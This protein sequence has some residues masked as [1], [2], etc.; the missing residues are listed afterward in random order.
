MFNLA[1][2]LLI[3]IALFY[4][5]FIGN[6][7][8]I[9]APSV[10]VML[11]FIFSTAMALLNVKNWNINYSI[12]T[13]AILTLGLILFGFTDIFV[14]GLTK[15]RRFIKQI[16]CNNE[17]IKIASW[18]TLLIVFVD[19]LIV[20]LVFK[21]VQR[22]AGTN[23]YFTNIF[24][25]YRIITSHSSDLTAEQYMNGIVSQ[26]MKIVIVSGFFYAYVYVNNVLINKE[27]IKKNILCLFPPI[28]LSV[29]TLITGVRTNVLRLVVFIMIV[30]YILWQ[31]KCGWTKKTSWKFVKKLAIALILVLLLFSVL[32]SVLGRTGSTDLFSVVSNYAGGPIQHF[33]QYIQDPPSANEVF[34]Q[35]TFTGVWNAL[36]KLK[37]VN[38]SFSAHEEF[39]YLTDKDF[40]NVYTLFR[41]F[42]QDFG[43][44]GMTI[45]TVLLSL[46][47]SWL[48]N[49]KIRYRAIGYRRMIII[50]EYGYLYYIV[51]MASIDNFVHDYINIGIIIQVIVLHLMS[52]FLVGIRGKIKFKIR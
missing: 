21:E 37:I 49:F 14:R 1:L 32:Q 41:R 34:G 24:Y 25:A 27:K 23:S 28:L 50:I 16:T 51:A 30:W 26:A 18:K 5:F 42:I 29:M 48:Y 39:R 13:V 9:M 11:V 38:Q 36:Y 35:E 22:I 7:Q 17:S 45:M 43:I 20:F 12:E 47:F 44:F 31:Y 19:L 15:N 4:F 46:F 8:D 2:L 3:E 6:Q 10:M 40:G 33:N 52:W